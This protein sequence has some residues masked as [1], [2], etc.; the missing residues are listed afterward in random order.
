M[1]RKYFIPFDTTKERD[2]IRKFTG[3]TSG[4]TLTVKS[5]VWDSFDDAYQWETGW[6]E[7]Y[8]ITVTN[9]K[10]EMLLKLQFGNARRY[11]EQGNDLSPLRS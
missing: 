8:I 1:K 11:F 2:R 9:Q 10:A 3:I 6:F 4:A 5:T 7:G